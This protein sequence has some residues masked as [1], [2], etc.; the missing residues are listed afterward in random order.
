MPKLSEKQ[1]QQARSVD[2]LDYLK[3]HEPYNVRKSKGSTNEYYMV[4]HDSLKMSN[5]KW[6]RHSTQQGGYSALDFLVKERAVH[7]VD[8][9]L[10]LTDGYAITDNKAMPNT[11]PPSLTKP[12]VLPKPN[13]NNDRVIA[14]LL[15]RGIGRSVIYRCI[16]IGTLYESD[17]HRCV[18]IGKDENDYPRFACERGITDDFKKDISGSIKKYSFWVPPKGPKGHGNFILALFESPIDSL[19]HA[20][21]HDFGETDWD[22]YRL[23]LGGTSSLALMSFLERHPQITK[24]YLCLDN[25]EP[26]RVATK[27]I[28]EEL[29]KDGRFTH[30]RV[31]KAPAPVGKD[32]GDLL[33]RMQQMNTQKSIRRQAEFSL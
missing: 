15:K 8:A 17:K 32:Y 29:S 25:D 9:V 13:R 4:E 27:R 11:L 16:R 1:I 28:I 31:A 18:F 5:G 2:L 21:I 14:Y 12:F 30:L 24:L 26:G 7:F 6:F 20:S 19:A 10:A 23:S 3:A 22:G 33:E